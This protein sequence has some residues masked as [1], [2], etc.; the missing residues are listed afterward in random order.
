MKTL[1]IA[2]LLIILFTVGNSQTQFNPKE[3]IFDNVKKQQQLVPKSG[4]D[5]L[6]RIGEWPYGS[7]LSVAVDSVR[8]IIFLGSG[9]AVLILDGTDKTNPQLITDPA[10]EKIHTGKG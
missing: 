3:E 5:N 2:V 8:N 1:H 7:S 9:G 6:E 4:N 10:S